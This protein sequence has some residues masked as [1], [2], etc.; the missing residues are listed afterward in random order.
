MIGGQQPDVDLADKLVPFLQVGL[1]RLL[2]R[3]RYVV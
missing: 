3:S 1:E 2:R